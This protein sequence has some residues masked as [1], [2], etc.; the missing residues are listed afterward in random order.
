[1]IRRYPWFKETLNDKE[2]AV[3][4]LHLAGTL[5][6]PRLRLDKKK[7]QEQLQKKL[8][9]KILE[10]LGEKLAEKEAEPGN[11]NDAAVKPEELLRQFL[12][13]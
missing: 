12:Q 7:V 9:K 2:E 3:V 1:L 13:Q 6:K 10:K 8:E 4:G 5:S 11:K